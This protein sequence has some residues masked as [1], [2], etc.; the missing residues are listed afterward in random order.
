MPKLAQELSV[1]DL[2]F[3]N[4]YFQHERSAVK[5][6]RLSHPKASYRTAQVEAYRVLAKPSVKGEIAKRLEHE[7][8]ITREFVQTNLLYALELA[9]Q[10]KDA[11][12]IASISMDCAKL[13]GFLVEKREVKTLNDSD[14]SAIRSL[15]DQAFIRPLPVV[16]L[17]AENVLNPVTPSP[18]TG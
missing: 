14:K 18:S 7:A 16:S 6:Y 12:V 4:A 3:V 13:A 2:L 17:P 1:N 9:N 10:V 11:A 5:A 15:V 8:G